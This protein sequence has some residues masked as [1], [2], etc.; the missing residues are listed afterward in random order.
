M[1]SLF[2]SVHVNT[3]H[4]VGFLPS[5]CAPSLP[6]GV[7]RTRLK[8]VRPPKG[9]LAFVS[10]ALLSDRARVAPT[11][12]MD[13]I[14]VP[15]AGSG[16][17]QRLEQ[18]LAASQKQNQQLR[19]ALG[20]ERGC[21]KAAVQAKLQGQERA[22]FDTEAEVVLSMAYR[23]LERGRGILHGQSK[24][25]DID[26]DLTRSRVVCGTVGSSSSSSSIGS[27]SSGRGCRSR[28]R[29][30]FGAR[31]SSGR[32]YDKDIAENTLPE[33]DSRG[34]EHVEPKEHEADWDSDSNRRRRSKENGR[35][36][37]RKMEGGR[38]SKDRRWVAVGS[39]PSFKAVQVAKRQRQAHRSDRSNRSPPRANALVHPRRIVLPSAVS[40]WPLILTL[41]P[42]RGCGRLKSVKGTAN[43]GSHLRYQV[44]FDRARGQWVLEAE[45]PRVSI[46]VYKADD[47][48]AREEGQSRRDEDPSC[49][50]NNPSFQ[51]LLSRLYSISMADSAGTA[52]EIISQLHEISSG[53]AAGGDGQAER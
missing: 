31:K 42:G 12:G 11:A 27:S 46:G 48:L 22:S 28:S 34:R 23:V 1:D 2:G 35:G 44:R 5:S 10:D 40:D 25:T 45:L 17:V 30:A 26:G 24:P 21:V 3:R 15:Q 20:R 49:A 18:E 33:E 16:L 43:R 50:P 39:Y 38:R 4:A 6:T 41:G 47:R 37:E 29:I 32:S 13:G 8:L 51:N 9:K 36:G 19:Q 14:Q 53:G 7:C 52:R